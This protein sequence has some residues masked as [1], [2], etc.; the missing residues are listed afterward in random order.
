MFFVFY[1]MF[2]Y[3]PKLHVNDQLIKIKKSENI[4]LLDRCE[5]SSMSSVIFVY[6]LQDYS[7]N[8][9]VREVTKF[10]TELPQSCSSWVTSWTVPLLLLF[11]TREPV[12]KKKGKG[13]PLNYPDSSLT[14]PCC[15]LWT[16]CKPHCQPRDAPDVKPHG[17]RVS[18]YSPDSVKILDC[19]W[20][21]YR[22]VE[23]A[24]L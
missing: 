8:L 1:S 10:S 5:S 12:E 20:R 16:C 2:E 11:G 17:W 15:D 21:V 6:K 23:P 14:V 18:A 3:Y 13:L 19:I 24:C 22:D 4:Y 7:Q 9:S